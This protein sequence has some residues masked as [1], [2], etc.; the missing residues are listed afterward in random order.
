[1]NDSVERCSYR[2]ISIRQREIHV[3]TVLIGLPFFVS[4]RPY[5]FHSL[6]MGTLPLIRPNCS[7]PFFLCFFLWPTFQPNAF[8]CSLFVHYYSYQRHNLLLLSPLL[9][10][11]LHLS[12]GFRLIYTNSTVF[13]YSNRSHPLFWWVRHIVIFFSSCQNLCMCTSV[14]YFLVT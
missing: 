3:R 5:R 7:S 13:I 11:F 6:W 12:F 2:M 1:M 4:I 14:F 8:V 9:F 10:P